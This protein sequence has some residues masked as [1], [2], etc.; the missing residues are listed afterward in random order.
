MMAVGLLNVFLALTLKPKKLGFNPIQTGGG[1][2]GGV[3]WAP[4]QKYLT[5]KKLF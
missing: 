4:T 1:G 2:G 3:L 5:K